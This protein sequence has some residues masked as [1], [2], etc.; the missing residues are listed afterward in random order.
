MN[1]SS[2]HACV[3]R[4]SVIFLACVVVFGLVFSLLPSGGDV[5]RSGVTLSGVQ[6]SL[7]PEQDQ[8][9][10]WKFQA[11][12]VTVDPLK[13]ENTLDGLGLGQRWIKARQEKGVW[14][15]DPN[16]QDH[17]DMTLKADQ[18]VI[19][20]ED[21]LKAKQAQLYVIDGCWSL[22]FNASGDK[23][24]LINQRT[25]LS[26]PSVDVSS[27]GVTLGFDDFSSPFNLSNM[28]GTQRA[29]ASAGTYPNTV[30]KNGR[31]VPRPAS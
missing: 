24:V 2:Y 8:G 27:P 23:P 5:A 11:R 16:G 18:L 17:L 9:A 22:N 1:L 6:F 26:A 10:V 28:Q 19:D 30:C 12:Q 29:G 25:G 31:I 13:N 21:N 20:G 4:A 3:F 7:Y 15:P 14:I